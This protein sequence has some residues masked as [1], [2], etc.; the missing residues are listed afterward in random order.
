MPRTSRTGAKAWLIS[1]LERELGLNGTTIR[2]LVAKHNIPQISSENDKGKLV[3]GVSMRDVVD[4]LCKDYMKRNQKAPEISAKARTE[5]ANA[6]Q[7]ET[8]NKITLR[9]YISRNEVIMHQAEYA[10]AVSRALDAIPP[11]IHR[12]HPEIPPEHLSAVTKQIQKARNDYIDTLTRDGVLT[13]HKVE[14]AYE[15]M[16]D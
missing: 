15:E 3:T 10:Q 16:F 12:A 5:I 11:R 4:A 1:E 14:D 6:V 8:Q 2:Q 9:Q 13:P 7:K